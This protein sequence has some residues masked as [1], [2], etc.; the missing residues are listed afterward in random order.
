MKLNKT[1]LKVLAKKT[2][3]AVVDQDQKV[4]DEM[5][6][7]MNENNRAKAEKIVEELKSLSVCARRIAF[8]KKYGSKSLDIPSVKDVQAKLLD[9]KKLPEVRSVWSLQEEILDEL[10]LSNSSNEDRNS[11]ETLIGKKFGLII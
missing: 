10:I 6:K 3:Y 8:G 5:K 9:Y 11:L 2:A 4:H 1:E 7:V